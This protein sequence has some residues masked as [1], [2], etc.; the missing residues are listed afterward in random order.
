MLYKKNSEYALSEELFKNPT[1]EY[2]G[3]PF[4]AWNS[5]LEK[6]ELERQIDVF[7]EMGLGGFHM[8]VRTG[9]KNQYL[10]DEYMELVN[11]CI[12]KAKK[13][14]MLAWLY[15]EDRWPSG[16]AGGF[17]T[18]NP[19][20]RARCLFF[21]PFKVSEIYKPN[22]ERSEGSRTNNGKIIACYD[23]ILDS[24]GYLTSYKRIDEAD[25]AKGT[26]W[27]AICEVHSPSN[28]YN[29][30][31]YADTLN[32]DAIKKFIEVTHERYKEKAGEEFD[33]TVPA[34]FTDEPQFSRKSV[35]NNSFDKMDIMMPWTDKVPELYREQYGADILD[36]LPELIWDLPDSEPSIH[37]YR[38]HDFISE[39][40]SS[41][42]ADTVGEW[43]RSNNIALTGHMMEEPSLRSQCAALGEA[44]RSYRGFDIPGIDMLCNAH[45]FTTAKQAQSAVH[46]FGYEG[47]LSELYGVTGWDCDFRT[48]KHQGDWQAALGVTVRVPHLSWYAMGGEAKRDYPAS[49]HYQSP[50]YKKY[51]A[52][53]DHFARVNT[54]LTRGKPVVKVAVIHPIESFWLH[55]GPNDKSALLRESLDERFKNV[56]TW[57]LEGSIDFNYISE[58]LF[59]SL[60]EKGSAPLKVGKMEYDAVIVP[61]CE[62]L[63]SSTV[64]RLADFR[65]N[66][67]KLIFMGDAPYLCDA[68]K[69]DKCKALFEQSIRIDFSR[70]AVLGALEENRTVTLRYSNG[71]LSDNLIY[72]LRKGNDCS[73]LFIC[74][75]KEPENKDIDEGKEIR[76]T[77]EGEF[78][79]ELYDTSD[80]NILPLAA[81]YQ[82][83][84]TVIDAKMYGYDSLL[85]KL[86]DGKSEIKDNFESKEI[87]EGK[88]VQSI[89]DFTLSEK[90][91]LVLDMAEYKLSSDDEFSEREEILRLD[92]IC[93][94]RLNIP[95]RGGAIVQPWVVGEVPP[96]DKITLRFKFN[97]EIN[98]K[99]ALLALEE[100]EKA[101]SIVFNGKN[102]FTQATGFYVDIS[103]LTVK[104]PEIIEGEN[105]L[106]V[107]YAYG[108]KTDIENMFILGDF[109][110]R[111]YGSNA[112]I[113]KMPEKISFGDIV[114]QG[115][116]FYGG[117]ITYKFKANAV[118]GKIK[119]RASWY[120]GGL[121][122][123]SVD[124]KE[125]GNI[126]YPPYV[127]EIDGLEDGEHSIEVTLY[128]H[129]YNTFGALHLAEEDRSWQGPGAW[130]STD[131]EWTYEYALRRTGIISAPEIL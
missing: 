102:V 5:Q 18:K 45:E 51:S 1:S 120:R 131:C 125:A 31:T 121:I 22:T 26:K 127:L 112:D 47:M 46:Q 128:I 84:K 77:V 19:E 44:M 16:A 21:S 103:I 55:W 91:V 122:S 115:L 116:P 58:S 49:I 37:R 79:P 93:R 53:E 63:R 36:T 32:K 11:D 70:A 98:Y 105:I 100:L 81:D 118:D 27:Y 35:L 83:G 67:G 90:N 64:E 80:G 111:A 97:S 15:D 48:Y 107:T 86:T 65:K 72:Q 82:N 42:F 52:I 92:N 41:S 33:K 40:F 85:I 113:V 101:E 130:R 126:I 71:R 69:S 23:I 129:R 59:E 87:S 78:I 89:V 28:W 104:L 109:G 117:N 43:C 68:V 14:K 61:G 73:W 39:L 99:G 66:G 3:T 96:I 110:V 76:I 62:T 119:L 50:W 29:S 106:E 13:E 6:E 108:E 12:T 88:S 124:G 2:R 20:Y 60:C 74:D 17:V 56:T 30:Q 95:E 114:S 8:H 9:L 4:W 25:E 7:K 34:I 94:N 24:N 75:N 57:L 123:V 54:A 38:Y 10:S